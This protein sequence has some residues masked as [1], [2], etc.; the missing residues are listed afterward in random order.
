MSLDY[1]NELKK[2]DKEFFEEHKHEI[3]SMNK[4]EKEVFDNIMLRH[5]IYSTDDEPGF[6]ADLNS[7]IEEHYP[8]LLK[9]FVPE[10]FLDDYR[11]ILK[12]FISFQ[13]DRS[14]SRRSFRSKDY[15]PFVVRALDLMSAYYLMS[16]RRTDINDMGKYVSGTDCEYGDR[17][18]RNF[19]F[20]ADSYIIAARIDKGDT[21]VI[22]TVR[23]M[24]NSE[25]NTEILTVPVI[26]AVFCCD[27]SFQV[28][29]K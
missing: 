4:A 20:D 27:T 28:F 26:R 15:S 12:K 2:F 10:I 22:E 1:E 9:L 24:M 3:D 21:R 14:Y 13:Y 5:R 29:K 7:Y 23:E 16:F 6:I 17:L 18:S 8:T 19:S 25:R 11:Y